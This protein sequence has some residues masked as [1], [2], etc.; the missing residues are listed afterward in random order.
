MNEVLRQLNERKSVRVF[1]D[2]EISE[3]DRDAIL[4]AATMAPSAGN[5]QLYT[6]LNIT[7]PALRA[8][9]ADSCDHQPFIAKAKMVLIF[10]ADCLKWRDAFDCAGAQAR[11]PGP[12][13][14]LLGVTDAAIAGQNA[15]SA[16]QSL[17]IGSCCCG[18]LL[19]N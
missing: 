13:D 19:E 18:H 4:R 17:G 12:G 14:L 11:K 2:R 3:A 8:K 15:V 5:Q 7:D 16:A 9:L 10:C 1:E 6:I